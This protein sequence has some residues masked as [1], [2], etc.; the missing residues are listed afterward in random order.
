MHATCSVCAKHIAYTL[1]S[2][3]LTKRTNSKCKSL[4]L[5][6]KRAHATPC[7]EDVAS[8]CND[9]VRA[10]TPLLHSCYRVHNGRTTCVVNDLVASLHNICISDF[11]SGQ[12]IALNLYRYLCGE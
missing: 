9:S 2:T 11:D 5:H 4:P 1:Y 3:Q 12:G 6:T 7:K 10:V 8:C